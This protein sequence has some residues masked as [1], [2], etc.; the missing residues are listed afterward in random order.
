MRTRSDWSGKWLFVPLSALLLGVLALYAPALAFGFIW[1]DPVFYGH[2]RPVWWQTL[3]PTPDFQFYRPLTMFYFWLFRRADG[4]FAA[5]AMHGFQI[6]F[7]LLNVVLVYAIGRRLNLG[8]GVAVTSAALF[9]LYPFSHQAIAWAVPHHPLTALFLQSSWLAYM[10]A[11]PLNQPTARHRPALPAQFWLAASLGLFLLALAVQENSVTLAFIPLLY[12]GLLRR[13]TVAGSGQAQRLSTADRLRHY[14]W[15]LLYVAAAALYVVIWLFIPRQADLT[16]AFLD[17]R[18]LP[19][20]LQ[21]AAYP[22]FGRPQGYEPG[23]E[24]P[25]WV[26]AAL[27][28]LALAGLLA[29]AAWRGRGRVALFGLAWALAGVAPMLAGLNYAYV[30]LGPRLLYTA[31]PGLA[32]LWGCALWPRPLEQPFIR[33]ASISGAVLVLIQSSWLLWEFQQ[34]WR[35]GTAHLAEAVAVL[36]E[37]E[38]DRLLFLNFPDRYA[39]QRRP[40]PLGYWGLTLA[41][42]AV[43]LEHFQAIWTGGK[44]TTSSYAMPWL[45]QAERE[46]GL[47]RVDMR[48]VVLQP[49]A[50]A[51]AAQTADGIYLTRYGID[52]RF[53]LQHAGYLQAGAAPVCALARFGDAICLHTAQMEKRAGHCEVTLTWSTTEPLPPH[54]TI[55]SHLGRPGQP[56]V[57]QADGDT[58]R[59]VLPLANWPLHTQIVD[60]RTLPCA[61]E[62]VGMALQVGVYNW[63]DGTRLPAV[64]AQGARPLPENA[65]ELEQ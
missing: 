46:G 7:H 2:V 42:V 37:R 10:V 14:R 16:G 12:E 24:W 13:P 34:Q 64:A 63:V 30:S 25:V 6:A 54:I 51:A 50:L 53:Q 44:A 5:E 9:A 40:Y 18:N 61:I 3:L 22:L 62:A 23:S 38:A 27:A 56:P 31:A 8:W 20:F 58:W 28:L 4:T 19:Y 45:D 32:L 33:I 65:W 60:K 55:F 26:V 41:P 29:L 39:P 35:V 15:P 17:G 52:G 11:R 59:G 47:Y 36:E 1:D 21:G 57:A 48:G 49:D 43:E